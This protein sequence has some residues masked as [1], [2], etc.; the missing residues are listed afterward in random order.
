[1]GKHSGLWEARE[2]GLTQHGVGQVEE[3]FSKAVLL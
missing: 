2:S 3:G 1:M